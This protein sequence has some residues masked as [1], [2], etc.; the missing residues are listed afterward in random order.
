[1]V[2][3]VVVTLITLTLLV[4]VAVLQLLEATEVEHDV[5]EMDTGPVDTEILFDCCEAGALLPVA[6]VVV[7]VA[8]R[9]CVAVG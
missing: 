2:D 9:S 3:W 6:P 1:M 5:A 7:G 8:A 4:I